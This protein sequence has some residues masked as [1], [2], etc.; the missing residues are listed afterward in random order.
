[1]ADVKREI[2]A[3]GQKVTGLKAGDTVTLVLKKPKP[4]VDATSAKTAAK[5]SGENITKARD[6]VSFLSR[7]RAAAS[8][9]DGGIAKKLIGQAKSLMD[10]VGSSLTKAKDWADS[11]AGDADSAPS[12]TKDG[13]GAAKDGA[14]VAVGHLGKIIEGMDKAYH[15]ISAFVE[16][17]SGRGDGKDADKDA[18]KKAS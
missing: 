10:Q 11:A 3:L 7:A 17:A 9:G 8:S 5:V 4:T 18:D 13:Y 15:A 14:A 16:E 6:A 2:R 1:M 12:E